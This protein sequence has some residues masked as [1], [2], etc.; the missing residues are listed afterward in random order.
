MVFGS[1]ILFS[2]SE[3]SM[4]FN[5]SLIA[6]VAIVMAVFVGLLVWAAV[7]GQRRKVAT[8]RE[9]MVGEEAEVKTALKPKGMVLVEGEL[10]DARSDE[11]IKKGEEIEVTGVEGLLLNVKRHRRVK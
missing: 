3:L 10:W 2:G 1:L 8:G 11:G 6:V 4:E 9:G 5:E 7:Q